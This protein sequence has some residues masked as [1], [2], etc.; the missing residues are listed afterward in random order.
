M[1]Y[2]SHFMPMVITSFN[3][4][5]LIYTTI[6]PMKETVNANSN[7]KALPRFMKA[8]RQKRPDLVATGWC[9]YWDSALIH[10]AAKVRER[11]GRQRRPGPPARG[12]FPESH[13][14]RPL[15]LSQC[16]RGAG[17]SQPCR[18]WRQEGLGWGHQDHDQHQVH[19][20][21]QAR[22]FRVGACMRIGGN[23][24]K[25]LYLKSFSTI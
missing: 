6:A 2:A 15:L 24:V 1:G 5:G 7:M 19:H 23:C 13:S 14:C 4:K 8:L 22:G 25:K 3:T 21:H 16:E 11:I 17:Q 18:Q 10:T 9:F 20:R 12:L